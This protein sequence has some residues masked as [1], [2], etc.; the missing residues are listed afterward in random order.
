MRILL[1]L[2]M[3]ALSYATDYQKYAGVV[4]D[5]FGKAQA[6]A[7]V[8]VTV[9]SS[10]LPAT[11]YQDDETTTRINPITTGADGTY[12]FTVVVGTY[13]ITTTKGGQ[14]KTLTKMKIGGSGGS[15]GGL[16]GLTANRVVVSNGSGDATTATGFTFAS[17]VLGLPNPL[18]AVNGGTGLDNSA[19]G[20]G[21]LLIGN[22]SGFTLANLTAGSNVTITNSAGGIEIAS[23]GGGGGGGGVTSV[24]L[25]LPAIFS[26]SGSPVTTSGTLTGSLATQT[27]NFVWSGPTT[28]AAATPTFRAL[29]AAD[30]P[31]IAVAN[32]GTGA[33][34]A[35]TARANLGVAVEQVAALF[36]APTDK[37]YTIVLA[38]KYGCTINELT[39]KTSN[40]TL[41]CAVKINGVAVTGLSAVAVTNS[42]LTSTATAANTV[43]AGDLIEMTTSASVAPTDYAWVLKWTR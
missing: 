41:T 6:G 36:E 21:K 22:G 14:T 39:T 23:G 28:G 19:A 20:D 38:M 40:G 1:L 25:A 3:A 43:V 7:S 18:T 15:S 26:V 16:S 31:T 13:T 12:E 42:L 4:Q 32:G 17:G 11:L 24:A 33:T 30:L 8:Y 27:A 2:L 35:A 34:T 5:T 9:Y 37:T 29:V 10:G